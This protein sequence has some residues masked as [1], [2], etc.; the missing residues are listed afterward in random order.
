MILETSRS[1]LRRPEPADAEKIYE[2]R[3]NPEV[4][5]HLGGFSPAMAMK[6]VQEWIEYHRNRND[7]IVWII[8]DKNDSACLGHV[9][10][11]KLNH[12]LQ[13]AEFAIC[14]GVQQFWG[15]GLGKEVASAVIAYGFDELHLEQIRLDV[16]E[17]NHRAIRL[18]E[19]L[20]FQHDGRLRKN[21]F[22]DG[23]FVDALIMSVLKCEWKGRSG[24]K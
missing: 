22:R 16:L 17:T 11:Y 9:G 10:L 8:A 7:D 15:K 5:R 21:Q 19:S 6:S 14:I 18:Y 4:V 24:T 20:G 23:Q 13:L 2:Y 3:N 1:I 12:R